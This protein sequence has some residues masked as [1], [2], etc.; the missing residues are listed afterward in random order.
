[1]ASKRS[2]GNLYNWKGG[3][4]ESLGYVLVYSPDHPRANKKYVF[5]HILKM[6]EK[7]GR[8]LVRGETV[9]HRNG[10]KNDNRIENLELWT[11]NHGSGCRVEDII[12]HST[13]ML[14]LYAPHLLKDK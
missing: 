13:E 6:E 8:F 10:I 14:M 5:E 7:I 12:K 3:R 1:M 4:R 11:K 2:I 9:H